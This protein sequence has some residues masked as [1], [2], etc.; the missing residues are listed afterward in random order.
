MDDFKPWGMEENA[1]LMLM[2]LSQLL[3]FVVPFAG[4]V[5]PIVMWATTKDQSKEIDRHGKVILNWL[6]SAFIYGVIS[7]I[8]LIIYIGFIGFILLL[9]LTIVFA[10]M[11]GINANKGVLWKYPLSIKF[12]SL[13]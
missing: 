11:G 4:V 9:I 1:F 7:T 3:G 13:D 2:H 6:I 5:M 8:L 12:L 10:I